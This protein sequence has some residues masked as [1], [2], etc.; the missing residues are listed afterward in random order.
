MGQKRQA[1]PA[2]RGQL[3]TIGQLYELTARLSRSTGLSEVCEAAVEAIVQLT[4]A[5]RASVLLFDEQGIMRFR[6]QRGLSPAYRSAVDGHSPWSADASDPT[7]LVVEDVLTDPSVESLRSVILG[8]GIR[9]LGFIPVV[10][11]GRLLGK[12]MLYH[13]APHDFSLDELALAGTIAQH[14]GFAVARAQGDAEV[15]AA[16]HRERLARAEA[17]AA[18]AEA[19]RANVAKDE[20]LAM[21]A[22]ELRNPLGAM[23]NGIAVMQASQ[24]KEP[25]YERSL[26][27]VRRQTQHLA[28]L[29]DDLL[30]VARITRGDIQLQRA[31]VD[32]RGV[33][34]QG[35]ENQRHRIEAKRQRLSVSVPDD[36]ITVIGDAVRLQ[37]VFGNI[38]HNASKYTPEGG[39][40]S[41]VLKADA[42]RAVVKVLDDGIGIAPDR[43]HRIFE[44]FH[45]GDVSL[46][47]TEG[48]LGIGLTVAKRLMHLHGGEV[49][50]IQRRL[51][52]GIAVHHR[53]TP[54]RSARCPTPGS[55]PE[56]P[57]DKQ[58]GAGY[59][60]Q[61]GR[62]R[63]A[64]EC[65]APHR[66]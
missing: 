58:T 18:R 42:A 64:C 13:N 39:A 21:L 3:R 24:Q 53:T 4:S 11:Q 23:V 60:R 63:D 14:V 6:A 36:P 62:T 29:L 12:F 56:C 47:R 46:A 30:D 9:A 43:L 35:M 37:Q 55:H 17:D 61:R 2:L 52:P 33:I 65:T 25:V 45:Q 10:Y 51:R 44:M 38:L 1:D 20:F 16:L 31:P 7:P 50:C 54:R 40:I 22:H 26:Q 59:R 66:A 41:I 8:E 57:H 15:E 27:A 32:M 49:C 34:E 5:Q 28:R 48:G 19:E